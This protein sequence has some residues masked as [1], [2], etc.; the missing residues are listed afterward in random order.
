M[1]AY[2]MAIGLLSALMGIGGMIGNLVQTLY[3]VPIHRTVATSAGLG[4]LI[5]IPGTVAYAVAGWPYLDDLPPLS[6]GYVSLVG[7]FI[8]APLATLCAPVGAKLAHRLSKR[9][10]EI[11]FGLFL[12]AVSIRFILA[13]WES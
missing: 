8:I 11:A 1:R 6:L 3:G 9:K 2:G 12:I 7:F 5:S 10:L 4:V 13:L